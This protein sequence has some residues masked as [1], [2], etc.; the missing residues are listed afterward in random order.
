MTDDLG[1]IVNRA[2]VGQQNERY[3]LHCQTIASDLQ[4]I[5]SHPF[6]SF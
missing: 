3:C 5:L 1:L 6:R 2:A 4:A